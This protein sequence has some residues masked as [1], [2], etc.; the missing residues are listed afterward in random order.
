[1][2]KKLKTGDVVRVKRDFIGNGSKWVIVGHDGNRGSDVRR[3][4]RF[5]RRPGE[6]IA[7]VLKVSAKTALVEISK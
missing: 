3:W 7:R 1:M 4:A 5:Q 2:A 6:R